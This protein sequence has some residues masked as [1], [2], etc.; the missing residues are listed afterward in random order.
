MAITRR[1]RPDEKWR[2]RSIGNGS[3]VIEPPVHVDKEYDDLMLRVTG[4]MLEED[5]LKISQLICDQLNS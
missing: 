5:K 2:T 3:V 1:R 4:N